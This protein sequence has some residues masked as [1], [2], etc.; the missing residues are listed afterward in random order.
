MHPLC[1]T[2]GILTYFCRRLD[3]R[4]KSS[5]KIGAENVATTYEGRSVTV[6]GQQRKITVVED[7]T[8]WSA[9]PDPAPWRNPQNHIKEA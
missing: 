4:K 8:D 7:A 1:E 6:L 3:S 9:T 2:L 5:T